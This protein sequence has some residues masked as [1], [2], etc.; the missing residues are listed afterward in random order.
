MNN[1]VPSISLELDVIVYSAPDAI[2]E[3]FFSDRSYCA[4]IVA[5]IARYLPQYMKPV[6]SAEGVGLTFEEFISNRTL[7]ETTKISL[8][9]HSLGGMR[10]LILQYCPTAAPT[11]LVNYVK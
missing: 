6:G 9:G 8:T 10:F 2:N 3:S 1:E 11:L 5:L 7:T 4:V